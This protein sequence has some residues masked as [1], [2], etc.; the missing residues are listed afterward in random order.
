MVGSN[1]EVIRECNV[2]EEVE[3]FVNAI[4][5]QIFGIDEFSENALLLCEIEIDSVMVVRERRMVSK[6]RILRRDR[7]GAPDDIADL[8]KQ[9]DGFHLSKIEV[10]RRRTKLKFEAR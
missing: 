8:M 5:G 7:G 3:D 4:A 10:E 9:D 6:D 2:D 1:G